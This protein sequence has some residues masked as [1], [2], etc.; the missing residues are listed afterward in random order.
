MAANRRFVRSLVAVI[1]RLQLTCQ[2]DGGENI[3]PP[4]IGVSSIADARLLAELTAIAAR[5]AATIQELG[6][7]AGDIRHK[8][9]GSPVT[10]AD[11]AS[12][13]VILEGLG[14]L[15][16]GVPVV[17]EEA[18]GRGGGLPAPVFALVDPLDGTR[19]FVAGRD[20]FAVNLALIA[21][22]DAVLGVVAAPMQGRL[23]RGIVGQGAE[24]LMLGDD[25]RASAPTVIRTRMAPSEGLTATM[26]RSHPDAATEAFLASLPVAGRMRLG[27]AIKF[28]LVAEGTADLYARLS[29]TC[30]WDIAAGHAVLRAAGGMMARRDGGPIS[31][32]GS[33]RG[34]LVPDFIAWGDGAAAARYRS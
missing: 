18:A 32:G 20:E 21:D 5:A 33:E 8:T 29:P 26:S 9:D 12:E 25:A 1:H 10:A 27:S 4:S 31:Y 34:F 6:R 14:R 17:S 23:W 7:Q 19:E 3:L 24:R 16:P 13:A 30:E 2:G 15:M 22:G 11:E 28:C